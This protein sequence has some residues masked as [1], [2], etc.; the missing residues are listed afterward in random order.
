M[1]GE[2]KF[3]LTKEG[4]TKIK[5]EYEELKTAKFAKTAGTESPKILHSEDLSPEYLSF[6][7]DI[8]FLENRLAELDY[9]LKN[10]E[11]IRPS[12]NRKGVI[13]LGATVHVEVTGQ[14]DQFVLVGS[15][16]AD[17]SVGRISNESP[18]GKA[19]L[20]HKVGETV[21]ISSPV[22]TAYKIKKIEYRLI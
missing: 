8:S 21:I 2:K 19:L 3:Y 17:P 20:G 16:E 18:V 7:E 1:T 10:T 22:K 13:D 14:E 12:Q 6:Q 4:L 15:L 5:K 9:I 11:I